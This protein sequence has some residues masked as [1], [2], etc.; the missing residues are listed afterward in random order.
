MRF[1]FTV[2]ANAA[3]GTYADALNRTSQ[4]NES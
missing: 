1:D 4:C 2:N 3:V